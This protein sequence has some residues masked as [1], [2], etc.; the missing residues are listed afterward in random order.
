MGTVHRPDQG[1]VETENGLFQDRVTAW[2]L[3]FPGVSFGEKDWNPFNAAVTSLRNSAVAG[4]PRP[5]EGGFPRVT[6]VLRH[7]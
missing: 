3:T 4:N 5:I 6:V 2:E 1:K 7:F